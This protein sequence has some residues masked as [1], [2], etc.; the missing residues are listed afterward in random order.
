LA[1]ELNHAE[2]SRLR[3]VIRRMVNRI[4]LWF[5]R[6]PHG[7][8]VECPLSKGTIALRPDHIFFGQ[9][10]RGDRTSIELFAESSCHWT[11]SLIA[12]AQ[13]LSS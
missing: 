2:P 10:S 12:I 3:K 4:E 9:A 5:D 6:V 13:A 7:K 8:R 11:N 1:D